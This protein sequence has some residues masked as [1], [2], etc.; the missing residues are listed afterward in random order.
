M[1]DP[2]P[3]APNM[4]SVGLQGVC[5]RGGC[6]RLGGIRMGG[7]GGRDKCEHWGGWVAME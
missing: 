2:P 7:Q 4:Y 6:G 1:I 5:Q 3:A